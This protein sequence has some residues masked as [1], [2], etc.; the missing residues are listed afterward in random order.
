MTLA[1]LTLAGRMP[2]RTHAAALITLI[3]LTMRSLLARDR[4]RLRAVRLPSITAAADVCR[5]AALATLESP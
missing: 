3:G 1:I 5:T 2:R 4:T